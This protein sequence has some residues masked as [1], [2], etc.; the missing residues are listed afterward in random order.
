[1]TGKDLMEAPAWCPTTERGSQV[2]FLLFRSARV[3]V[4]QKPEVGQPRV[5]GVGE[6]SSRL[7]LEPSSNGDLVASHAAY[8]PSSCSCLPPRGQP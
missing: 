6:S 7:G 1:M 4:T 2:P 5:R 8:W 3:T